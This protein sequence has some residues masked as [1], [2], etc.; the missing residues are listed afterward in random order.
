LPNWSFK[1][2]QIYQKS[3]SNKNNLQKKIYCSHTF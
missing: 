3:I 2:D 1:I